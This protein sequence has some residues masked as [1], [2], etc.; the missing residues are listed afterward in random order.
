M[1][2]WLFQVSAEMELP[3]L[4]LY[5]CISYVDKFVILNNVMKK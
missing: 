3:K 1:V 2:D 4:S 5:N